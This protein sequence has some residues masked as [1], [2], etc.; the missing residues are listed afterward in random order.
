[1]SSG[2]RPLVIAHRGAS[3][4]VPE[5]TALA[6]RT[7]REQGSD[8]VELDV[9]LAADGALIV[10]HDAWYRDGRTVW[11]T[12]LAE[13]PDDTLVLTGALEACRGMGVNVEI[14][15]S[16]GDLA[17]GP[18]GPAVVDATVDVLAALPEDVRARILVSSFD[19]PTITRVKEL[20]PGLQTG[21]LVFDLTHEPEAVAIAADGGHEA[22][23]PWDPLV[24]DALL[25]DCHTRG[26]VVNTWTVDDPARWAELAAMGIDG[27]VTN[28]PGRLIAA[29]AA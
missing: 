25:E 27:I 18:G 23:H 14:K 2:V 4:D 1:M 19:L 15:N 21:F 7:A 10:N 29:L 8:W 20:D 12:P 17:D 9:R 6:F 16:D 26:L 28:T 13:V 5:N 22:L 24:T 11:S 3:A